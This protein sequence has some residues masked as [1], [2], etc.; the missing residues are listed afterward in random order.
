MKRCIASDEW[1]K[2][3]SITG[4]F[5]LIKKTTNNI[6]WC[7]LNNFQFPPAWERAT[8]IIGWLKNSHWFIS[9]VL[10]LLFHSHEHPH[11]HA[12]HT[13]CQP[14]HT[15]SPSLCRLTKNNSSLR[16]QHISLCHLFWTLHLWNFF[17]HPRLLVFGRSI[18]YIT[19]IPHHHY[20]QEAHISIIYNSETPTQKRVS[21]GQE[22]RDFP[23][24]FQ[25]HLL[26]GHQ[27]RKFRF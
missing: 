9:F 11:T 10:S 25:H 4:I 15:I 8:I 13:L 12:R 20:Q 14:Q 1:G 19:T 3:C 16:N 17:F 22:H 24:R 2:R 5:I 26:Q 23:L 27:G 18:R 21:T 6:G 7:T